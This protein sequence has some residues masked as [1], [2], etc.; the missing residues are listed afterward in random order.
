VLV[1]SSSYVGCDT[2]QN[3]KFKVLGADQIP[4]VE[5]HPLDESLKH[6]PNPWQGQMPNPDGLALESDSDDSDEDADDACAER[7]S[8]TRQHWKE[9][10]DKK[11]K[12]AEIKRRK[13]EQK[14]SGES[15]SDSDEEKD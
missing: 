13:A 6:M 4:K 10:P 12:E 5:A 14:L 7:A 8:K 9:G 15:S 11:R 3:F 1:K 2:E